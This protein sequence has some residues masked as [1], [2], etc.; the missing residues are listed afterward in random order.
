MDTS[1]AGNWLNDAWLIGG[2]LISGD[3][4]NPPHVWQ[5]GN[6]VNNITAALLVITRACEFAEP[7][8]KEQLLSDAFVKGV[9]QKAIDK[10]AGFEVKGKWLEAYTNCYFWLQAIEPNN[11]TYSD[12]AEQLLDKAGIA[13]SFQDSPCETREQR[14]AGVEKEM[15]VRAIDALSLSYVS[16]IDYGQMAQ[17][18]Y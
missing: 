8:Q 3:A 9:L 15:F 6:D 2:W 10:A 12:Y 5:D 13:A 16:I 14:Y 4:N 1:P 17:G 7:S 11:K 18:G